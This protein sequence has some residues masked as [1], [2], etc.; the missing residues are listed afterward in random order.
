MLAFYVDQTGRGTLG[1]VD[2]EKRVAG[3]VRLARNCLVGHLLNILTGK[4]QPV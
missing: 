3:S 4:V 1:T 2:L